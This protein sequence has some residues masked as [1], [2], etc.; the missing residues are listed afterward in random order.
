MKKRISLVVVILLLVACSPSPQAIQTAIAQTQAVS[1]GKLSP[2]LPQITLVPTIAPMPTETQVPTNEPLPTNPPSEVG[3]SRSNP[4]PVGS[5]VS[6]GEIKF[7]ITGIIRP[8]DSIVQ[9]GN[10]YNTEPGTG[11]EYMFV[12]VK[13]TCIK[14]TD[15]QCSLYM[16]NFKALGSDGIQIDPSISLS[17]VEGLIQDT[18]FYGGAT[19]T[20]I[21]AYIVTKGDTN[22][23]LVD[24]T[25]YG[26]GPTF[27]LKIPA[28]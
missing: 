4:G 26:L 2:T 14:A 25:N 19:L 11:K 18:T 16:Y 5:E 21:Y 15:Q 6:D 20:G 3:T 13:M 9:N 27:Y 17:G 10:P 8:A 23:L 7:S 24:G 22:M 12:T 28:K 1:S